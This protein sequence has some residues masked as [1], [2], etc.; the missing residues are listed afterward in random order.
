MKNSK[1]YAGKIKKLYRSL[2]SGNSA[3]VQQPEYD[4]PTE[5]IVFA[6]VSEFVTVSKAKTISRRID[7]HFVNLNDLRVAP[8]EEILEVLGSDS[9][10]AKQTA[11][12]L[13]KMLNNIFIKY[14]TVSLAALKK[15]GKRPAK[16]TIEKIVD[17]RFVTEYCFLTALDG[18]SIPLTDGMV[19]CLKKDKLV[20]PDA[21][22]DTIEGF[23]ARQISA[24]NAY[25]FYSLLRGHCDSQK[26]KKKV[27]K[28]KKVKK[29]LKKKA[30]KKKTV[31]KKTAKKKTKT[32][33]KKTKKTK[34]K[35]KKKTA[36]KKLR[37]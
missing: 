36:K 27:K 4:D 19:A 32:V 10:D 29:T 22:A 1:E 20:Y 28:A 26:P 6:A 21:D 17:N 3:K 8:K 13:N 2:R 11:A 37:K 30:V 18:H 35:T 25:E 7:E 5:A 15:M 34:K 24:K 16:Q 23:L 9:S 14:H 33:K 12:Q 31:K